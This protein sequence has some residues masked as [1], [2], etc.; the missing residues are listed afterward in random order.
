MKS[1]ID[2][3]VAETPDRR[4]WSMYGWAFLPDGAPHSAVIR[5]N[6]REIGPVSCGWTRPDVA[7][8]LADAPSENT[9]FKSHIIIPQDVPSGYLRLSVDWKNAKGETIAV[10][11]VDVDTAEPD[12]LNECTEPEAP[13]VAPGNLYLDLM[14]NTLTGAVYLNDEEVNQRRDGRDWP[15]YA[16]TMVGLARLHHLRACGTGNQ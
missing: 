12:E 13:V 4:E 11:P 6:D 8:A 15:D 2:G 10:T 7:A 5:W 1:N 14:E 3:L 16:H 9:G